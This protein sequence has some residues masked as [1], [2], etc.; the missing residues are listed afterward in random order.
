[1]QGLSISNFLSDVMCY[2]IFKSF[3]DNYELL[4]YN[5]AHI[6]KRY[7]QELLC[8]QPRIVNKVQCLKEKSIVYNINILLMIVQ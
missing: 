5:L 8:L 6:F 4:L 1:M 2:P 3:I 7:G